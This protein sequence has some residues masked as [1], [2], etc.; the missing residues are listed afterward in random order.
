MRPNRWFLNR[1]RPLPGLDGGVAAWF[2]TCTDIDTQKRAAEALSRAKNRAELLAEA[3]TIFERSFATPHL[4]AGLASL[5]VDSFATFC[6]YDGAGEDGTLTRRSAVHRDPAWQRRFD[7][8]RADE[9]PRRSP[10][11]PRD[12]FESGAGRLIAPV[13]DEWIDSICEDAVLAD[14]IRALDMNSA[15][16]VPVAIRGRSF[17][18]L[19]LRAQRRRRALHARR[20]R[21]CR[22]VGP[23]GRRRCSKR[24]HLRA[25]ARQR[26][27]AA[28]ITD[29]VPQIFGPPDADGAIDWFNRRW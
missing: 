16:G 8:A 3:E 12:V 23:A 20:S 1:G 4:I 26:R 11:F 15:M 7:E 24:P 18:V 28:A 29:A 5:A 27:R 17:G 2:G 13:D 10:H 9:W 22:R 19:D 25:L 6:F 14:A 21:Q